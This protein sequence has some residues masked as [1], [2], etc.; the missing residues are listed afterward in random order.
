M[1]KIDSSDVKGGAEVPD[2]LVI[3]G[4]GFTGTEAAR[5]AVASG[6]RVIATTRQSDRREALERLG[7]D[8]R[9]LPTLTTHDVRELVPE[10]ARVLVTFAPDG[11]TDAAVAPA[12]EAASRIAYISTTGVY[13]AHRGRVDEATPTDA[14]EPRARERLDAER[15]YL[16]RGATVLRAAGIY[17]PGRGL[18]LRVKSGAY[19]IP[20]D[21]A[22]VVSRIH[23]A[24]LARLALGALDRA[25]DANIERAK[26][27]ARG[28]IFVVADDAPVPQIEAIEWL[29]RRF[30]VPLPARV[31]IDQAPETLRHDRAVDNAR[32]KAWT[33]LSLLYPSYR[34]G[35]AACL[36]QDAQ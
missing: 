30:D 22:N 12:L 19:R 17:G 5:R 11:Q 28:R 27:A 29:C 25:V 26:G 10:G 3:L 2:V 20:G 23:V 31:P 34:E 24:D 21:G 16:E 1:G 15:L 32:I 18:H 13:G 14:R 8:V 4:C 36:D 7:I 6:G 9:V 35:F 33:G